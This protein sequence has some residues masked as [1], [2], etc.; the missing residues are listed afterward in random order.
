[1]LYYLTIA[2]AVFVTAK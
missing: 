1:M 2:F